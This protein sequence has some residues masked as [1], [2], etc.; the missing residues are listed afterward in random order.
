MAITINHQTND[1]SATSGSMTI[2]GASAG[3]GV[4]G[5]TSADNTASPNDT[6]NVASLAVNSSS[7]NAGA[8]IVPKGTGAFMLAIPDGTTTGGNIRGSRA[9]DLGLGRTNADRVASGANSIVMG[10]NVKATGSQAICMG[11]SSYANGANSLAIGNDSNTSATKAINIL[12]GGSAGVGTNGISIGEGSN[13]SGTRSMSLQRGRTATSYAFARGGYHQPTQTVY[14]EY[15][16]RTT[17]ATSATISVNGL[18]Q[19]SSDTNFL[20]IV[21][22]GLYFTNQQITYLSGIITANDN[23]N[24]LLRVLDISAAFRTAT[25][26]TVTQVGSDTV[27]LKHGEGTALNGISV[28]TSISSRRLVINVTGVASTNIFWTGWLKLHCSRYQ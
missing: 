4:T 18:N 6:T 22:D 5:F 17:D 15:W 3:G 19:S 24:N 1:I 8:A 14:A 25:D 28:S 26:G 13:A 10:Y 12:G 7:T 21:P 23:T 16:G 9:I 20:Q 11:Y 27:N 2:D